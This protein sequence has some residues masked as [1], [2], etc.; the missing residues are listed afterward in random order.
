M[1]GDAFH[2]LDY[3]LFKTSIIKNLYYTSLL[4]L[5]SIISA[6]A[7]SKL[8]AAKNVT[9]NKTKAYFLFILLHFGWTSLG[10]MVTVSLSLTQRWYITD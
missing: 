4:T 6:F 8:R 1:K 5:R 3:H 9:T 7:R 2:L 10:C